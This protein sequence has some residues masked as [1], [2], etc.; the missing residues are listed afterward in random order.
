MLAGSGK[1][2]KSDFQTYCFL[3][4]CSFLAT[5]GS[6]ACKVKLQWTWIWCGLRFKTFHQC[7]ICKKGPEM[8]IMFVGTTPEATNWRQRYRLIFSSGNLKDNL[9]D[10]AY[11]TMLLNLAEIGFFKWRHWDSIRLYWYDVL[12]F[13]SPLPTS[14]W[15]VKYKSKWTV[16]ATKAGCYRE[17]FGKTSALKCSEGSLEKLCLKSKGSWNLEIC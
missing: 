15:K 10:I 8:P 9:D 11:I 3:I 14:L 1:V 2:I 17:L 6:F 16:P 7:D 4:I 5:I 12:G 13:P